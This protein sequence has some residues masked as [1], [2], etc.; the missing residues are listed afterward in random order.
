MKGATEYNI[1]IF[2]ANRKAVA[3]ANGG[4]H[5]SSVLVFNSE[6]SSENEEKQQQQQH[7]HQSFEYPTHQQHGLKRPGDDEDIAYMTVCIDASFSLH[8]PSV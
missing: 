1:P 4:L 7:H 3:S 6:W 8:S 5:H 2:K